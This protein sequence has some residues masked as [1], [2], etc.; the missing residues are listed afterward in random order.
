MY[1]KNGHGTS[2]Q[3][4][5]VCPEGTNQSIEAG[6]RACYCKKNYARMDRYGMCFQCP[7]DGMICD[8]GYQALRAGYMWDWNISTAN[9]TH[10]ANFVANLMEETDSPNL[11]TTYTGEVPRIFKCPRTES[12][13]NDNDNLAGNCAKGYTGWLCTRCEPG[14]YSVLTSCVPC[15]TLALPI[16]E[17]FVFVLVCVVVCFSFFWRSSPKKITKEGTNRTVVGIIIARVK[18]LLGFY[19]VVGEIFTSLHDI[20]WVSSLIAVGKLISAVETNIVRMFIRPR[21]FDIKLDVNPKIQ[22]IIGAVSPIAVGFFLFVFY[23]VRNL[24]VRYKF[25]TM[26]GMVL[27]SYFERLKGQLF[28]CLIVLY[29]IMY[30]PVCSTIFSVYPLCCESFHLGANNTFTIKRLRS[31]LDTDCTDLR[32]YH[33]SAYV[34]TVMYVI[35]FPLWLF[36]LLHKN[37]SWVTRKDEFIINNDSSGEINDSNS[38]LISHQLMENSR[39]P[40][41]T[42]LCENYKRKFWFWEIVEL[43]RKVTQ[44]LLIT[45]FGWQNRLTV[46]ITTFISVIFLLLHARYRPMKST[47]EQGLQVSEFNSLHLLCVISGTTFQH[48]PYISKSMLDSYYS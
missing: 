3:N 36:W 43:I 24:Y 9:I 37:Y 19:Q 17:G 28:A 16:F 26:G 47:Y 21:C 41:I 8:Q 1:V 13:P 39:P 5:E 10:Y 22:F 30:P 44:T 32:P 42:F 40:W 20:K 12:C 46:I 15:P 4:C 38:S 2:A 48:G 7:Q 27:R 35:T 11:P 45:L 18:I 31:D 14:Y 33:I 25:S 34:L 23:L 6:F 29:F